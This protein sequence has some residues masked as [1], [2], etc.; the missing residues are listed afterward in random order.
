MKSHKEDGRMK[1]IIPTEKSLTMQK[2]VVDNIRSIET[3]LREGIPPRIIRFA[4]Q[5]IGGETT[6]SS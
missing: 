6:N 4:L 3:K 1:E 2:E 5:R